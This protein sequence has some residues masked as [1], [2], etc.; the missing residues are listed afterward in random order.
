SSVFEVQPGGLQHALNMVCPG[1]TVKLGSGEYE[2]SVMTTIAGT[3]IKRITIEGPQDA[4]IKGDSDEGHVFD[5]QHS[6]YTLDGFT[7]DGEIKKKKKYMDKLLY[8]QTNREEAKE[9]TLIEYGG[10]KFYSS[11]NGVVVK[12]MTIRNGGGE[13]VRLRYFVT[14]THIH[15]NHIHDCGIDDYVLNPGEGKNGEAV[16]IGTAVSQWGE[17]DKDPKSPKG[18]G[19]DSCRFNTVSHNDLNPEGNECVDIKEGSSENIIQNNKCWGQ[20]DDDSAGLDSRGDSNIFRYNEITATEGS[21]IRMG[22][23]K[24]NGQQ[25][26]V[27]NMVYGNTMSENEHSGIKIMV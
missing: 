25:F 23:H 17:G 18:G 16:Y 21:G 10:Q 20:Y 4:I 26:G 13:C 5:V 1:D 27:N 6:Y 2:E 11:I 19:E 8:I 12:H 15:D 14:F 22:G 3:I 9:A 24:V 7:I